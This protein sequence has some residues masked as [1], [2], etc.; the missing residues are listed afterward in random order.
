MTASRTS[1]R[2]IKKR[3]TDGVEI[4]DAGHDAHGHFAS[5]SWS[6]GAGVQGGPEALAD[7]LHAG[8]QL[9]SLK[10]D[11]EHRFEHLVALRE[12]TTIQNFVEEIF[13]VVC[14]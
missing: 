3:R 5:V 4:F 8:L 13:V 2:R 6:F 1:K 11:D 10:E 7:L 12:K 14:C 9:V